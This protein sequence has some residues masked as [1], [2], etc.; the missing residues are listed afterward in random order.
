MMHTHVY[1][2]NTIS[3]YTFTMYIILYYIT[4]TLI[5]FKFNLVSG[6]ELKPDPIM[7]ILTM[8]CI[9]YTSTNKLVIFCN[10][11]PFGVNKK[12]SLV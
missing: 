1:I 12:L 10:L 5:I 7:Q 9:T 3:Y 4:N 2:V 8:L 6:Y 11:A